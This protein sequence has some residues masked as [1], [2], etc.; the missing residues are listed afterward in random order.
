MDHLQSREEYPCVSV[1]MT[2]TEVIKINLI[3]SLEQRHLVLERPL[4]KAL[5]SVLLEDGLRGYGLI[6]SCAVGDHF[7]H[8]R[9]RVVLNDDVD[10]RRKLDIA[11][12]VIAM[13]MGVDQRR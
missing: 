4:R 6:R 10:R 1:G 13:G 9:L 8:V 12:D 2:T 3:R 11:A 7:H 5:A